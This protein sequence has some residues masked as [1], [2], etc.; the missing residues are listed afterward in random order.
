[1]TNP[2]MA[3]ARAA[4]AGAHAGR[5][6]LG[7]GR[8][9]ECP[10]SAHSK[11][12][13]MPLT[14]FTTSLPKGIGMGEETYMGPAPGL[15]ATGFGQ[16]SQAGREHPRVPLQS[17]R[18]HSVGSASESSDASKSGMTGAMRSPPPQEPWQ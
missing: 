12:R 18:G 9:P 14:A 13:Q 2:C 3:A 7:P 6:D 11:S 4:P 17:G 16:R 5:G 1:M 8:T 15:A 10:G